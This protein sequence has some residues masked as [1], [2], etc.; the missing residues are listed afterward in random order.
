MALD[1]EQES[2]L[3]LV[4]ELVTSDPDAAHALADRFGELARQ[5]AAEREERKEG[6]AMAEPIEIKDSDSCLSPQEREA[7]QQI[8]RNTGQPVQVVDV[9]SEPYPPMPW[10]SYGKA[11]PDHYYSG[12]LNC[13]EQESY[14]ADI[15]RG[16][17]AREADYGVFLS[18]GREKLAA[19]I[20]EQ[21]HNRQLQTGMAEKE[22]GQ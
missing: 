8:S 7:A 9:K 21:E 18:R 13:A 17:S 12:H 3:A 19:E 5:I 14:A 6:Q 20:R 16:M 10:A 4:N 15:A 11:E 1:E 2:R 22:G